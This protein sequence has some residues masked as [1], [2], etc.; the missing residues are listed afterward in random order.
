MLDILTRLLKDRAYLILILLLF[1]GVLCMDIISAKTLFDEEI[2][3]QIHASHPVTQFL[4]T[5]LTL[6][7]DQSTSQHFISTIKRIILLLQISITKSRCHLPNFKGLIIPILFKMM[8]HWV[9][10]NWHYSIMKDCP[11]QYGRFSNFSGLYRLDARS[12]WPP[13]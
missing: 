8:Q 4:K 10:Q 11:V 5:L 1:I 12:I 6:T 7:C 2:S 9:S 3:E 13:T